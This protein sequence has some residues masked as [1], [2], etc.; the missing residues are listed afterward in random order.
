MLNPV[1][2]ERV[3]V[4]ATTLVKPMAF[5]DRLKRLRQAA[6]LTQQRLATNAG[7]AMS[8]IAQLESGH[9]SDPKLSTLQALAGALGV[10]IQELAE[11]G[12]EPRPRRKKGGKP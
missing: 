12:D 6:G 8:A 10:P 5:K 2:A 4:V 9:V 11:N 7:L 1:V 3:T